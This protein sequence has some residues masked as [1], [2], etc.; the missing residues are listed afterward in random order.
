MKKLI[1]VAII[2][3]GFFPQFLMAQETEAIRQV[4]QD[5]YTVL[6]IYQKGS[7]ARAVVKEPD[8]K[9]VKIYLKKDQAGWWK[10]FPEKDRPLDVI[11][12]TEKQDI[13]DDIEEDRD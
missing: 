12:E 11:K 9:E 2:I 3:A 8:G 6:S 5:N 1:V 7:F 13:A 10:I 4:L